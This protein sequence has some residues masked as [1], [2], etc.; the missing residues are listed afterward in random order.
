M[1]KPRTKGGK[2]MLSNTQ[3]PRKNV[4]QGMGNNRRMEETETENPRKKGKKEMMIQNVFQGWG[5][6]RRR[7]RTGKEKQRRERLKELYSI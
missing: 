6:K 3:N 5:A 7:D 2:D 4:L 1:K